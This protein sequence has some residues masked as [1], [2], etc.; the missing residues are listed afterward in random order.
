[1]AMVLVMAGCLAAP[2][3]ARVF[4]VMPMNAAEEPVEFFLDNEALFAYAV[5]DQFGGRICIVDADAEGGSCDK[6]AWGSAN[7]VLGLGSQIIPIEAPSLKA[8]EWRLLGDNE[9][10]DDVLSEVFTVH[11]CVPDENTD[12][13]TTIGQ[14]AVQAYKDAA[15][16][17]NQSMDGMCRMSNLMSHAGELNTIRKKIGKDPGELPARARR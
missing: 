13:S 12:C 16:G 10:G 9:S 17:M 3:S 15:Q 14:Q 2:A 8:G 4:T 5:V 1:M 7:N 11:P 6:P